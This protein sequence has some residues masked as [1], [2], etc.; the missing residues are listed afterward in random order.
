MNLTEEIRK[1][2]QNIKANLTLLR[3]SGIILL[4][5][6]F[7]GSIWLNGCQKK[8]ILDLSNKISA[9]NTRN[10]LLFE[11]IRI[12]DSVILIKER[13]NDEI[14]DSDIARGPEG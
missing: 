10:D 5:G 12:R 2:L 7:V 3:A 1:I 4:L 14:R 11:D 13:K 6:I 8:E 9:L